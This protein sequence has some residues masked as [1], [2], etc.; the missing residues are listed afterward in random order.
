MLP[1]LPTT[2]PRT[3]RVVVVQAGSLKQFLLFSHKL[4]FFNLR[5]LKWDFQVDIRGVHLH[6]AEFHQIT[7]FHVFDIWR[8]GPTTVCVLRREFPSI[9]LTP[10]VSVYDYECHDL[11]HRAW[12]SAL[13]W[14]GAHIR[15]LVLPCDLFLPLCRLWDI[16][17]IIRVFGDLVIQNK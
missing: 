5:Y 3:L 4:R 7:N 14:P 17:D 1:T 11:G 15:D 2:P 8:D 10:I 12:P 13:V 6:F 9:Q 16:W